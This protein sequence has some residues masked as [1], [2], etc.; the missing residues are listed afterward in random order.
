MSA[1]T[2]LSTVLATCTAALL[3][4]G[5]VAA[6][7]RAPRADDSAARKVACHDDTESVFV[8]TPIGEDQVLSYQRVLIDAPIG[9]VWPVLRDIEV[10]VE[11]VLPDLAPTFMWLDGGGPETIPSRFQFS[12]GADTLVEEIIY[13]SETEK[14]ILVRLVEPVLGMQQYYAFGD[15]TRA[16]GDR[17]VLEYTR[18][19]ELAPGT[20]IEFFRALF[21]QEFIDIPAYF[22]E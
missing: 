13:R 15:L 18:Y 7:D 14:Q 11:A 4:T 19:L 17:T 3:W 21:T 16:C 9:E 6:D 22:E 12:A 8:F 10:F 20:D 2:S 5:H 1:T